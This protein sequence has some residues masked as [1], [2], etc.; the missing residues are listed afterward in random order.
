MK[1]IYLEKR[2][3]A[4]INETKSWFFEKINKIDK[5]LAR[6]IKK[7]RKRAQ[8]NKIRNEN[9]VTADAT[10]IQKIIR[11]Y[12]KQ[13]LSLFSHPVMSDSLQPDG[14]QHA[15][16]PCPSPSLR[17][18]SNSRPLSRWCHPTVLS[19]V[20]PIFSCFWSFPASGSFLTNWLFASAGQIIGASASAS[21]FPMNIQDSFPLG[22]TGLVSLLSKGLFANTTVQKASIRLIHVNVWQKPLKYCKVISLQLK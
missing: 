6:L 17:A 20:I 13:L 14:L 16:L 18:C 1:F 22:L 11:D 8:L 12:W 5:H 10:E 7:N 19:S 21:V 3:I 2:T 4:K 9:E 15:R